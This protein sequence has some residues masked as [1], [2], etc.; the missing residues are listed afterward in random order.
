[1]AS[2]HCSNKATLRLTASSCSKYTRNMSDARVFSHSI[3]PNCVTTSTRQS[4]AIMSCNLEA[5][6]YSSEDGLFPTICYLTCP[7]L[8]ISC[9][10]DTVGQMVTTYTQLQW[11]FQSPQFDPVGATI[12]PTGDN[13][14]SQQWGRRDT[15]SCRTLEWKDTRSC[16]TL[17]WKD[18]RSCWTLEWRDTGM[19]GH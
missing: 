2:A 5:F 12:K 4:L 8:Y 14:L 10:Q 9:E 18:T 11:R 17:E 1:L 13:S 19:E 7:P 16:R 3:W 6:S 15:R